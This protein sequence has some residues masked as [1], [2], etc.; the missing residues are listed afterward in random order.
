MRIAIVALATMACT[1]D[2]SFEEPEAPLLVDHGVDR[3][4]RVIRVGVINDESGPGAAIGGPFAMGKRV[5]AAQAN[6]PGSGLL[7][8]GWTIR[9]EEQ[10]ASS[11]PARVEAAFDALEPNVLF[12]GTSFGTANTVALRDKLEKHTLVAFPASLSSE[13]AKHP[14]TPPLGAS[15][16][17]EAR[18]GLDFMVDRAGGVDKLKVGILHRDD[19]YGADALAGFVAAAKQYGMPVTVQQALPTSE[20]DL[21][22]AIQ[23]LRDKGVTHVFLAGLPDTT[24][25]LLVAA[26]DAEYA[27]T[28][29]GA[30][31]AW[32]DSFFAGAVPSEVFATYHQANSLPFWGEDVPGMSDVVAAWKA[33]ADGVPTGF[34]AMLSYAQG[35]A[36]MAAVRRAVDAGD[37]TREGYYKALTSLRAFDGGGLVRPVD[38]SSR[39]YSLTEEVRILTPDFAKRTWTVSMNYASPGAPPRERPG[40]EAMDDMNAAYPPGEGP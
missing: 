23:G 22:T 34:Y 2:L 32:V 39:P 6:A 10:D 8:D 35:L 18:R 7:P 11:D 16:K 4:A 28:W 37:L 5:L 26:R 38:L 21:G 13:M 36:A 15:Y 30:T 17:A 14:F 40:Q 1:G 33:H 24:S 29:V 3:E 12:L 25:R 27:P 19:A 9:L 20:P 31:P